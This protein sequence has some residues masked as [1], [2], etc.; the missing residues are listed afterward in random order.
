MRFDSSMT[1]SVFRESLGT[2][3]TFRSIPAAHNGEYT[4]CERAF[5]HSQYKSQGKDCLDILDACKAECDD[6][7][8][9]L[10]HRQINRRPNC[11]ILI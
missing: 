8:K 10:C 1:V 6:G 11:I 2:C 5:Q 9:K 4:H 7:P 3:H